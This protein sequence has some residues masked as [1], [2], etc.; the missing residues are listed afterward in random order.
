MTVTQTVQKPLCKEG[1]LVNHLKGMKHWGLES[2]RDPGVPIVKSFFLALLIDQ[3]LYY[4][5]HF[6]PLIVDLVPFV[7]TSWSLSSEVSTSSLLSLP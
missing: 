1:E 4:K 6:W 7:V 3:I 5:L 2:R